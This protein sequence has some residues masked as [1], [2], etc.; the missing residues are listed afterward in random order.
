[1]V[2][3]ILY[4]LKHAFPVGTW[5]LT[6]YQMS[7]SLL[8]MGIWNKLVLFIAWPGPK[9]D[10]GWLHVCHNSGRGRTIWHRHFLCLPWWTRKLP[11]SGKHETGSYWNWI[12][13]GW[14]GKEGNKLQFKQVVRDGTKHLKILPAASEQEELPDNHNLT[15]EKS[16]VWFQIEKSASTI[17]WV[18]LVF[19]N[20]YAGSLFRI[21]GWAFWNIFNW[22]H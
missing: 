10:Q 17:Q 5:V 18:Q 7:Y 3:L 6:C 19:C 9:R 13:S 1:M 20:T 21:V 15:S 16:D 8:T 2:V 4:N 12:Y 14:I 11:N 22:V